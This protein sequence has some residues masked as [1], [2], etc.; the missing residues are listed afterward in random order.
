MSIEEIINKIKSYKE[1]RSSPAYES[2]FNDAIDRVVSLLNS[3]PLHPPM[4]KWI[5]VSERLPENDDFVLI[6]GEFPSGV[7]VFGQTHYYSSGYWWDDNSGEPVTEAAVTHWMPLPLHP[8]N[9]KMKDLIKQVEKDYEQSILL[10]TTK[11]AVKIAKRICQLYKDINIPQ[12]HIT[13]IDTGMGTWSFNGYGIGTSTDE[14]DFGEEVKFEDSD[15]YD[16]LKDGSNCL[17]VYT[18]DSIEEI[19]KLVDFLVDVNE[20]NCSTWQEGFNEQGVIFRHSETSNQNNPFATPNKEYW[21]SSEYYRA[22]VK[23]GVPIVFI[24]DSNPHHFSQ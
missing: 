7:D 2:G 17:E 12:P 10:A 5:P 15:I 14:E 21:M 13:G 18:N 8:K 1:K 3:N 19:I 20:L 16:I 11:A 24:D 22:L 9:E 4:E 6:C 23:A